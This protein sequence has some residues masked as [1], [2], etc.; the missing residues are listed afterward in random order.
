MTRCSVSFINNHVTSV[1]YKVKNIFDIDLASSDHNTLILDIYKTS[2]SCDKFLKA[3]LSCQKLSLFLT[4][5][6]TPL[7]TYL[8]LQVMLV[9]VIICFYSCFCLWD[10]VKYKIKQ[11]YLPLSLIP[12]S[13]ELLI[14]ELTTIELSSPYYFIFVFIKVTGSY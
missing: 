5:C 7:L 12:I 3:V 6:L 1:N 14:M 8:L 4:S 2:A 10:L 13:K 9:R 11:G